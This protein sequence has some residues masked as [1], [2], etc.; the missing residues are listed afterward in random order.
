MNI[1][2]KDSRPIVVILLIIELS[3]HINL[4]FFLFNIM[5]KSIQIIK[6]INYL[7]LD[8]RKYQFFD[9]KIKKN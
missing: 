9:R 6:Q 5:H 8:D 7:F 4:I 2:Q 3:N 1:P